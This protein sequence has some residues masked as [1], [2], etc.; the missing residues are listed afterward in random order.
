MMKRTATV[1]VNHDFADEQDAVD[2]IRTA[3]AVSSV[4]TALYAASPLTEGRPNGYKSFRAEV[5]QDMDPARC[6]LLARAFAAGFSWSDY[7]AWALEAPLFFVA[8]NGRYHAAPGMTF[9]RFMREGWQ[10]QRP[11]RADWALHLSTLFPEVRLKRTIELRGADAGPPAFVAALPALWRGLLDDPCARREA[12]ALVARASF[13]EQRELQR[14]IPRAGLDVRF[15]GFP[16]ATLA[17]ELC[18]IAHFGLGRL[19][20]GREDQ[21]LLQPL[22]EYARK[23]RCPADDMLDDFQAARGDRAQL[24]ARWRLR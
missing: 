3:M 20:G 10:G 15:A 6:G 24:I 21:P 1:Q 8:R 4:V 16:L 14:L 12:R 9:A 23:G 18:A 7:A 11:T 13:A 19:P 2:K 22:S 5:W 17:A